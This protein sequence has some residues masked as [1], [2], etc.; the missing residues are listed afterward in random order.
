MYSE[1]AF[2]LPRWSRPRRESGI[3][4]FPA[5]A[6]MEVH[7]YGGSAARA[8]AGFAGEDVCFSPAP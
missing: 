6:R 1:A 8:A 3:E 4:P 5:R 2:P 7:G